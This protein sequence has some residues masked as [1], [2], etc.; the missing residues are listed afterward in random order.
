MNTTAVATRR[1]CVLLACL[2]LAGCSPDRKAD[3]R[4]EDNKSLF[5]AVREADQVTLYEG[6]PHQA[7]ESKQLEKEKQAKQTVQLHGFPFYSETLDLTADDQKALQKLLGDEASFKQWM[8]EKKCGGF[9]PDYLV[10]WRA[11]DRDYR[12]L[13]CFGCSEVM[14]FGPDKSLRCDMAGESKKQLED[15]LKKYQKNRPARRDDD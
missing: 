14:V 3:T 5:A 7:W 12:F 9:H 10:E 2:V 13:I 4:F 15:V 1:N 8:G 6:L 11:G